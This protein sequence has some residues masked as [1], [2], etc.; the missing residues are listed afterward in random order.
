MFTLRFP[1]AQATLGLNQ[2]PK[3]WLQVGLGLRVLLCTCNSHM[4]FRNLR[5][6]HTPLNTQPWTSMRA[7]VPRVPNENDRSA[8]REDRS[9]LER[10]AQKGERT[11]PQTQ[12]SHSKA[13]SQNLNAKHQSLNILGHCPCYIGYRRKEVSCKEV[14]SAQVN[15][16]TNRHQARILNSLIINLNI[17]SYYISLTVS[18][19]YHPHLFPSPLQQPLPHQPPLASPSNS[20]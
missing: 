20:G 16:H 14:K 2:S 6:I 5:Y 1:T 15:F 7:R 17:N 11:L 13:Q 18:Q 4:C 8:E 10:R 12:I 9:N 3:W 19:M